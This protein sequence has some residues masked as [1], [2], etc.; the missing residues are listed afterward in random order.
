MNIADKKNIAQKLQTQCAHPPASKLIKLTEEG[1][2]KD[3]EAL[4]N[5]IKNMSETCEI[6]HVYCA[7]NSISA[8]GLSIATEFN[9]IIEM[10]LK[11]F[12][13]KLILHVI[14]HAAR[15]SAATFVTSKHRE[16]MISALFKIWISVFGPPSKFFSDTGGEVSNNHFNERC[17]L[18][19]IIVK[20]RQQN[21]HSQMDSVKDI[22]LF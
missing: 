10:D 12:K 2:F 16:E 20:K 4:K 17:E 14:D 22:I 5:E 11:E 18:L 3:D 7:L 15:F 8:V 6:C 9:E 13:G 19:N 21:H 1:G